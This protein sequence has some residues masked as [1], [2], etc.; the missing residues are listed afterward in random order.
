MQKDLFSIRLSREWDILNSR[1]QRGFRGCNPFAPNSKLYC[2]WC[3]EEQECELCSMQGP[4]HAQGSGISEPKSTARKR[5]KPLL[6]V[7]A[8]RAA[9]HGTVAKDSSRA[10][11]NVRAFSGNGIDTGNLYGLAFLE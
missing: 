1:L 10:A 4:V 5:S 3:K 6:G 7:G 2:V 8:R 11:P 9:L